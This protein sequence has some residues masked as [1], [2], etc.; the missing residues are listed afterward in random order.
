LVPDSGSGQLDLQTY[1]QDTGV[2][3]FQTQSQL[4]TSDQ[5][6]GSNETF[7]SGQGAVG[8]S[9][10]WSSALQGSP[11]PTVGS[12]NGQ[13]GFATP[14]ASHVGD[15]WVYSV[16]LDEANNPFSLRLQTG[17]LPGPNWLPMRL[18]RAV[19]GYEPLGAS[20]LQHMVAGRPTS[21]PGVGGTLRLAAE[22]APPLA[23]GYLAITTAQALMMPAEYAL[24][25]APP[26]LIG[27]G[28]VFDANGE[29]AESQ[30][31]PP[32]LPT[33]TVY[34]QVFAVDVAASYLLRHSN[35]VQTRIAPTL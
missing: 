26:V 34:S 13:K 10:F 14:S 22:G 6:F 27:K 2:S 8:T 1:D 9:F 30:P 4:A 3:G 31:L 12:G 25:L 35:G 11:P 16:D 5:Y 17:V 7:E 23:P 18:T 32:N 28:L 20:P 29:W 21:G 19:Q 15:A 24:Y 33:F